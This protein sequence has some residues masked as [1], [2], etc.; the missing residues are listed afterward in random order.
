MCDDEDADEAFKS[1]KPENI[2]NHITSEHSFSMKMQ[3]KEKFEIRCFLTTDIGIQTSEE[4]AD[5]SETDSEIHI[6]TMCDKKESEAFKSRS[7]SAVRKHAMEIHSYS[8]KMQKK[9]KSTIR[10]VLVPLPKPYLMK[11]EI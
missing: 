5:E 9:Y 11:M 7:A 1:F 3:H 8:L 2:R 10:C 6:C 4:N